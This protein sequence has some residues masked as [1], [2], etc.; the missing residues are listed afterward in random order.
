MTAP[1]HADCDRC[2]G[3]ST[4][5]WTLEQG[6]EPL[7]VTNVPFD[8]RLLTGRSKVVP[9]CIWSRRSSI[10]EGIRVII[11]GGVA[12]PDLVGNRVD[13]FEVIRNGTGRDLVV[14]SRV[15][16]STESTRRGIVEDRRIGKVGAGICEGE[17]RVSAQPDTSRVTEELTDLTSSPSM[18]ELPYNRTRSSTR[19]RNR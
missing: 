1:P 19:P 18:G 8:Q 7:E 6:L 12:P 4:H 16:P 15:T 2:L 13:G 9:E 3:A 10:T 17:S 5:N 11:S 14:V